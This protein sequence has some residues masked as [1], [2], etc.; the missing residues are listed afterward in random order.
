M[1]R[2][3]SIFLLLFAVLSAC[4]GPEVASGIFD[5]LEAQNRQIH[6]F[7][8]SVDRA[9]LRPVSGVY[10]ESL[11]EPVRIGISNFAENLSLPGVVVNDLLQLNIEDALSNTARFLINST[12]GFAGL[13]DPAQQAGLAPRD[14]DFGETLY[15]WGF[16][17]GAYV[18]VPFLGPSTS[19]AAVGGVVDLFL[20]PVAVL[21]PAPERYVAPAAALVS[22]FG[23]RFRFSATVDSI[24]YESADSYAQSR[25]IYLENRRFKLGVVVEEQ[26]LY[27]GLYDGLVEQ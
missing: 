13:L 7:N 19:R 26:D 1:L 11:P 16:G 24:L 18:V 3:K 15:V 2:I 17:E 23:D 22:K 21:V 12:L 20:D 5:P 14:T 27:E 4:A 6:E 8:R 9:V 10:G 25:L